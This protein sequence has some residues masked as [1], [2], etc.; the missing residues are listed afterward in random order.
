MR[1]RITITVA[2]LERVRRELREAPGRIVE[3]A[4][5]VRRCE[6]EL[7]VLAPA[8]D[9]ANLASPAAI[10]RFASLPRSL[11]GISHHWWEGFDVPRGPRPRA[12]V[13]L[14]DDRG[15]SAALLC[16]GEV[17]PV[18]EVL[19]AGPRMDRW[20]P[21]R[22]PP[23][24]VGAVPADGPFSRSIGA[25]GG[26][27]V[28]R[29]M[30]ALALAYVASARVSSLHVI[31]MARAGVREIKLIDPDDLETHS[32]DAVEVLAED[33]CGRPKVEAVARMI[34]AVAPE[35][36]VEAL[37][38][39]VDHPLAAR[40]CAGADI[41]ISAPDQNHARLMAA[42]YATAYLRPH[43][44]LGTGVFGDGDGFLAGA[45]LRLI[46]PG[47]GC[48]LC[49]GSLDL[50]RRHDRD[51]RRQRAGSL[52]SLN[53][54]AVSHAQF[55]L[56]RFMVGDITQST[57]FQLVLDRRADLAVRRMPRDR[58]PACP[59]CAVAGLGDAATLPAS[60]STDRIGSGSFLRGS[61]FT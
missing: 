48:L 17:H 4:A 15:C 49:V 41:V 42:L 45:D 19:V 44:D 9:S 16:D 35:V 6:G 13:F 54:L 53:G 60:V 43:L 56:E 12:D 32:R 38:H 11:E 20:V 61:R 51:W 18:V 22:T 36:L 30:R 50:T 25:L 39:P 47:D 31:G 8:S 58:D 52:R 40:A 10:L 46:L 24:L 29:R 14:Y 21:T 3:I 55:L 27:G 59:L 57:W 28:H 23:D 2:L 5:G 26:D 37:P 34:A 1:C 33:S 7:E